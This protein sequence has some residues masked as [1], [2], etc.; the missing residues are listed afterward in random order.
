VQFRFRS[1]MPDSM[2]DWE[3]V[4]G[5]SVSVTPLPPGMYH[6]RYIDTSVRA[7]GRKGFVT[8]YQL[9]QFQP[10]KG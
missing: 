6:W 9:Q 2:P 10:K 1:K 4:D 8:I 5:S 7:Q 3:P